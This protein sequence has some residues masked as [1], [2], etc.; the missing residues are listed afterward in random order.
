M[1]ATAARALT[2]VFSPVLTPF[3]T[4]GA[5]SPQRFVKH[6]RW[7]VDQGVGLSVFGTNS[8]ANSLSVREKQDL[9]QALLESGIP[10]DV[11]MPGTGLCNLPET[12][13]LTS[14]AVQ[15]GCAGVLMLPPFYYK[16]VSDEGLFRFFS[17]VI[18]R[19]GDDRLRLYVYH[20]PPVSQVPLSAKL[21][22][23]LIARHGRIIAGIKDSSGDWNNTQLM[24]KHFQ[25]PD[26]SVF[27]GSE[28]FLLANM[29]GGGAGC[30]T[31]TGNV[32][33]GAINRLYR[34]WNEDARAADAQQ[35]ALDK[36][37]AIFQSMPIIPAMKRTLADHSGD[38]AWATV[39]P[40]LVELDEAQAAALS[41]ALRA[42]GFTV[43]NARTLA[44]D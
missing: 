44:V 3:D 19:V 34:T 11:L 33:P 7:L 27:A 42:D 26:F 4:Q 6:C 40:P 31:A 20:I 14:H 39:R 24:L 23:R 15:A 8:E 13:A 1:S 29:R 18:D 28:T 5:I 30:I 9:L 41:S 25:G 10:G 17:T 43:P 2:G 36:T 38:A 32:N 37:R 16:G 12:V 21:I 35:A 22:E